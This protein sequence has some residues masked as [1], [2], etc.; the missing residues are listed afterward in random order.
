MAIVT[1]TGS[2]VSGGSPSGGG[3]GGASNLTTAGAVPYVASAGVLS[4]TPNSRYFPATGNWGFGTTSDGNYKLDIAA[5]GSSGTLRVYDQTV[6]TGSTSL[7]VRAGAGQSGNLLSVQNNAGS[8]VAQV[9]A[10]GIMT[11]ATFI[12]TSD[13]SA[14]AGAYI[15]WPGRSLMNAPSLGVIQL[16]D[17]TT[18]SFNRLQFGGTTSSFPA[19]KRSSATLQA[20]LADDSAFATIDMG[21]PKFSG[22]N[23]TGAGSALLGSNSPASTLTAPYTWIT[24]LTSDGSTGY[25]PVWK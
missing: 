11:A 24:V 20:R 5:S 1:I 17:A 21:I 16:L 4:Q 19:L 23:S 8:V 22:T 12:A 10:F 2:D 14:G 18:T 13:V 6:T 7:V 3:V 9:D 25:I 15:Y